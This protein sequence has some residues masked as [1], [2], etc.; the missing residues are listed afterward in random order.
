M[1]LQHSP[2][3]Y[4][5][6]DNATDILGGKPICDDCLDWIEGG[7]QIPADDVDF[8]PDHATPVMFG[9]GDDIPF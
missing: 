3:E 5:E 8:V 1:N 6:C 9:E 2:C 4:C 7:C